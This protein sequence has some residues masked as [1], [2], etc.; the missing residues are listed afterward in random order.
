MVDLE[1]ALSAYAGL[2]IAVSLSTFIL[3]TVASFFLFGISQMIKKRELVVRNF[4][5]KNFQRVGIFSLLN[6]LSATAISAWW[7]SDFVPKELGGALVG[8]FVIVISALT[9]TT[10][11][12]LIVLIIEFIV[13]IRKT[14]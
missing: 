4:V 7:L 12:W 5:K 8:P 2:F 6:G 1:V 3:F 11:F 14:L 13:R 10:F 9:I